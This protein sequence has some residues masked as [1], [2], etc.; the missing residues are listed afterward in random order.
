MGSPRPPEGERLSLFVRESWSLLLLMRSRSEIAPHVSPATYGGE[1]IG[2]RMRSCRSRQGRC[3]M[4][5]H[6]A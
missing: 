1:S 2:R 3:S 4:S 6:N 5:M